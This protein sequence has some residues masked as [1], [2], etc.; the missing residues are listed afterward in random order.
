MLLWCILLLCHV[1]DWFRRK[2]LFLYCGLCDTYTHLC[3][4]AQWRRGL[5]Y[6]FIDPD[7]KVRWLILFHVKV[8]DLRDYT[9]LFL[10]AELR[11]DATASKYLGINNLEKSKTL[12]FRIRVSTQSVEQA[13][14]FI[15]FAFNTI[16]MEVYDFPFDT[17]KTFSNFEY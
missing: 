4:W 14:A 6:A 13:T 2:H 8:T 1:E 7:T 3:M 10:L 9:C 15:W 16:S 17:G 12:I 5:G 11:E